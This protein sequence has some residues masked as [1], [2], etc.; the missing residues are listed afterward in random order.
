M[1]QRDPIFFHWGD[2]RVVSMVLLFE[3]AHFCFSEAVEL[4][5]PCCLNK[6]WAVMQQ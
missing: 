5:Y 3:F 4:A 1:I 2:H 6:Y